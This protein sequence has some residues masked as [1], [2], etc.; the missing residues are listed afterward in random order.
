M[1]KL[2][3]LGLASLLVAI[4]L[5]TSA[6]EAFTSRSVNVRAGPD[7]S[8]P[9]VATLGGGAPVEVM[10]CL[11]DWSW[12]D[13]V[14][15]YNRGWVYAPYLTYVYQGA[16]VPFY[17]YAPSFGIPIVAF[18]LGSYWDRYY[19]GR[20]WYGRRDYWERREPRHVRPLGPAPR[21]TAPTLSERSQYQGG[22]AP[23]AQ[24]AYT[25]NRE[26]P[27]GRPSR[28]GAAPSPDRRGYQGAPSG[29][30]PP[31]NRPAQEIRRG[32]AAQQGGPPP[33]EVRRAAP[34]QQGG[35]PQEMRRA[36]PTQQAAPAPAPRGGP[37]GEKGRAPE[38]EKGRGKEK[39][40][41]G[42]KP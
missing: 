31:V 39:E 4:P 24:P 1:R 13:V 3:T 10:G 22:R 20:S 35:P 6:Q 29:S 14:F 33:Q 42:A 36:S 30:P 17:T 32:S 41:E 37:Q 26:T 23:S 7:T 18:S 38:G 15:G 2:L 25:G 5:A 34:A 11:D 19:R 16:R 40:N 27:S 9:A 8:Y 21:A 12:C 28:E